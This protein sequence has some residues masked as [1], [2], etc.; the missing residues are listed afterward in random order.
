MSLNGLDM[1]YLNEKCFVFFS[2][3]TKMCM[4]DTASDKQH[5]RQRRS[6]QSKRDPSSS[7]TGTV[8]LLFLFLF[9]CLFLYK[10]FGTLISPWL[11][12]Y[13]CSLMLA[14]TTIHDLRTSTL[15]SASNWY[16][17]ESLNCFMLFLLHCWDTVQ[18]LFMVLLLILHIYFLLLRQS[19]SEDPIKF[20]L[21]P[22]I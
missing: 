18:N 5:Q 4:F 9:L 19:K 16:H 20:I 1:D 3:L 15:C 7:R 2:L 11:C 8:P 14:D 10:T 6:Y 22:R 17:C 21:L 13:N 12:S